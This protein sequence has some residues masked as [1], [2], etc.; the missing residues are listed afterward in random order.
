MRRPLRSIRLEMFCNFV[1]GSPLF[2]K[3]R[4]PIR[5]GEAPLPEFVRLCALA[6]QPAI[7][8]LG[9]AEAGLADRKDSS[10]SSEL[11]AGIARRARQVSPPGMALP[12]AQINFRRT[13]V[14]RES[15]IDTR[16]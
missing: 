8:S 1:V 3:H 6:T 16:I 14:T 10:I 11:P 12:Q 15:M 13:G 7:T 9:Q 5:R 2:I 4:Q